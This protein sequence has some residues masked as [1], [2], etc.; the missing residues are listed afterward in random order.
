MTRRLKLETHRHRRNPQELIMSV[1]LY[2]SVAKK[3]FPSPRT[4]LMVG[5]IAG[6]LCATAQAADWVRVG[7]PDQHQ[8]F[9]DRSKLTI[10]NDQITY[11]R[12][13]LFRTPQPA[14]SGKARMAMY[15]ER[16]DCGEHTYRTLGYLFYAQDGSILENVYTPDSISQPIIP[17]SV[18]DR[19]ETLM[20]LIVEQDQT[21]RAATGDTVPSSP[22]AMRTEVERLE[23]RLRELKEQLRTA[24][25][26]D[27]A[28]TPLAPAGEA[29]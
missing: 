21:S 9:Y 10:D 15:R 19:F 7:T 18:G 2:A 13:V 23:A 29:Q 25:P 16:V 22:E 8:H 20:C 4:R 17:E 11:W 1:P 12:R 5:L 27:N 24:A 6:T 26:E 14:R 28:A 3:L